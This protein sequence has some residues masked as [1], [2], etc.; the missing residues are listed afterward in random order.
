MKNGPIF[1]FGLFSSL[2]LSWGGLVLG[3]NAQLGNLAPHFDEAE[4]KAFPER[5]SGIAARGQLVYAELGCAACHTQQVRRPDFGTDQLR[6]W[7]ERQNFARDYVYQSNVQ[8]GELRV[9]PDLANLAGRK[10][11]YDEELLTEFLYTGVVPSPKAAPHASYKFLFDERRIVG[12]RSR[13]AL[14]LSGKAPTVG[15]LEIVP[16][17]KA[18]SLVA[19]LLSLNSAYNYPQESTV[20]TVAPTKTDAPGAPAGQKPAAKEEAHK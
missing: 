2:A 16:S 14:K 12:E 4:G 3:T 7:G 15:D 9:G 1:F 19:Y 17:E 5:A 10:P 11:P 8:L 6:G 13:S 18:K 20:N